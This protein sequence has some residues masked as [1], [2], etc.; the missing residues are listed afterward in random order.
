MTSRTHWRIVVISVLAGLLAFS[1]S[2]TVSARLAPPP[3]PPW[4]NPD[5][6]VDFS[7]MPACIPVVGRTGQP[8]LN[9]KG[10][11]YC[12]P[13]EQLLTLPPPPPQSDVYGGRPPLVP[14]ESVQAAPQA[15]TP[16]D[17]P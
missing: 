10:Q 8:I 17:L 16:R 3:P 9:S 1:I 15:P 12:V 7:K 2:H 14:E 5:G 13:R 4:V 11:P 6:T